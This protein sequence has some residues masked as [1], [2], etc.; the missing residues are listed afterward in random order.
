MDEFDIASGTLTLLEKMVNDRMIELLKEVHSKFL[1]DLD[2]EELT[3]I[4]EGIKKKKYII[5][6]AELMDLME[7]NK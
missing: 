7:N 5:K 1:S 3:S 2:F 4:L 6:H